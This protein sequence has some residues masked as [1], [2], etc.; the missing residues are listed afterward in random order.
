MPS[1]ESVKIAVSGKGGVG[2]TTVAAGL[3]L[4]LEDRGYEIL[5]LDCDPD[6]NL[7]G[8]LGFP[9]LDAVRPLSALSELI[10]ERTGAKPGATPG[11]FFKLN[12]HVADIPDT[13]CHRHGR[14]KL[15]A[16]DAIR[17]GG[18]GCACAQNVLM[19]RLVREVVVARSEA[20]V[21]DM[22]AGLEHL[23]RSTAGAVSSMIVVIEPGRR[24]LATA[25]SI[26]ALAED[27]G[28]SRRFV[29]GNR[30]RCEED[31]AQFVAG[32]FPADYILGWLAVDGGIAEADRTGSPL[33]RAMSP[34]TREVIER[35]T[36]RLE[37]SA[38]AV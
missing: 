6:S 22:E 31:F 33:G 1:N 20:V 13:Y 3:C 21:M 9:D 8:C 37:E 18:Q 32:E 10:E 12:P 36:C 26:L 5:A 35:V 28:I 34:T 4:A 29:L 38:G 17:E 11:A 23:G 25:Q 14:I 15:V 19:R 2:K 16:I 30:F 7:A 24:S 27:L